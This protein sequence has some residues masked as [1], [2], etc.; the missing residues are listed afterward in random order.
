MNPESVYSPFTYKYE[1]ISRNPFLERGEKFE[2][3][4]FGK[5]I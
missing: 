3:K 4:F 2:G 5:V 1:A